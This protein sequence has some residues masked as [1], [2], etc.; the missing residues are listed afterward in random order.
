MESECL[1]DKRDLNWVK[2]ACFR[3]FVDAHNYRVNGSIVG[4]VRRIEHHWMVVADDC[5]ELGWKDD[6]VHSMAQAT[7]SGNALLFD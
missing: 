4:C 5:R 7:D 2:S 6:S 1:D 3:L